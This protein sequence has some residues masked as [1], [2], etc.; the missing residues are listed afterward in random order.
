MSQR[1]Y[2]HHR[3]VTMLVNLNHLVTVAAVVAVMVGF[4]AAYYEAAQHIAGVI[5]HAL[6][7]A[8]P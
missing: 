7:H 4:A 8:S 6:P 1:A 5:V 3:Q 2:R